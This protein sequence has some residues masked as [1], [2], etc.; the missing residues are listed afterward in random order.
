[1]DHPVVFTADGEL[2]LP[3]GAQPDCHTYVLYDKESLH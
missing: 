1:M 2:Y 3:D